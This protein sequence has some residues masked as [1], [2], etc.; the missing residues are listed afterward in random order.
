VHRCVCV[1]LKLRL[2][3]SS[4]HKG[5][6]LIELLVV[7][8]IIGIL[9]SV[10]LASLSDARGSARDAQRISEM[11]QFQTALELFRN[12]NGVYP[13][14][15]GNV[16]WPGNRVSLLDGSFQSGTVTGNNRPAGCSDMRPYIAVD[17]MTD[18]VYTGDSDYLYRSDPP[19][20]GTAYY[21]RIRKE[22]G[23][24]CTISSDSNMHPGWS[25]FS[26]C[27]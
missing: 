27:Y 1:M 24:Y 9:A 20:N 10:V 14:S 16:S 8:A 26:S 23:S 7:I 12:N 6:T 25:S 18:P 4:T 17:S 21:I 19:Q 22:N 3:A 11:R 2:M 13:C 5:F 15:T